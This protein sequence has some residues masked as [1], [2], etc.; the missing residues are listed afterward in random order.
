MG[1]FASTLFAIGLLSFGDRMQFITATLAAR[2]TTPALAAV[3]ATLGTLAVIV[4]AI[5][6]G[7]RT[8]RKVPTGVIRITAAALLAVAGTIQALGALRLI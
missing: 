8:L 7:E 5:L 2:S 1:A 3:G 4:P 6:L